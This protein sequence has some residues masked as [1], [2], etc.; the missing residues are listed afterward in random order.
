MNESVKQRRFYPTSGVESTFEMKKPTKQLMER[1]SDSEIKDLID[2]ERIDVRLKE[3]LK[4]ELKNKKANER[5]RNKKEEYEILNLSL[6]EI[7][8]NIANTIIN[9][10]YDLFTLTE[11]RNIFN[12]ITL[13]FTKE[14]RLIYIGIV[15][16]IFSIIINLFK[17]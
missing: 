8:T 4:L 2:S 6:H 15:I 5:Y 14:N 3:M 7:F 9:I 11:N 16:I 17:M 13:T 10:I 12:H 1:L